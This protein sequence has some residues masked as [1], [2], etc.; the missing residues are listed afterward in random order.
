VL[1]LARMAEFIRPTGKAIEIIITVLV[2]AI[3]P[4]LVMGMNRRLVMATDRRLDITTAAL[5]PERQQLL[6]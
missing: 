1:S 2:T 5:I 4:H 3:G 6:A